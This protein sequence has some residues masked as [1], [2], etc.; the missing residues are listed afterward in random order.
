MRLIRIPHQL[1][2][3]VTTLILADTICKD[4]FELTVE[5]NSLVELDSETDI[6]LVTGG[7]GFIGSNLVDELLK[8]DMR[9]RVLDS[10]ETGSL[11]FLD[12]GHPN[13]EVFEGT[14]EDTEFLKEAMQGVGAV[15]HIAAASKVAPSL[16]DPSMATWN[17]RVNA[18]GT[19][20][21]LEAAAKSGTV[22]RFIYAGS[23]T[24]Y[25]NQEVPFDESASFSPTSPYAASK[26]M[27]E[28]LTL[29]YDKVFDLPCINL[30]FFMVY[31]PRQ[32][33]TG[34]YA[35]VSGKFLSQRRRNEPL[36]I[37]GTGYQFRDF[38]HV[39][40]VVDALIKAFYSNIRGVTVNIGSGEAHTV[41]TIADLISP[42]QVHVAPRA[43]DLVGTLANTTLAN[44]ILFFNARRNF[45]EEIKSLIEA[46]PEDHLHP[47]WTSE[48]TM[49]RLGG[50]IPEYANMTIDQQE[51]K[52]KELGIEN[53][54]QY[55][56]E[57]D[58]E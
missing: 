2:S 12:I 10:F 39:Q 31:G 7:A 44:E 28:L 47:F 13:L 34:P 16:R 58:F 33:E 56:H 40:D 21:V 52:I 36:T 53:I 23:S 17:V 4:P 18:L 5:D 43:H 22:K 45:H 55:F 48:I 29:T 26:Y 32:P 37:E 3:C 38:I 27:G 35:V 54:F 24:Y 42:A 41:K 49:K 15:F 46:N 25:G 6:V 19:A 9:V 1:Y 20:N 30:R 51:E 50:L 57:M 8:L 14:V 11:R